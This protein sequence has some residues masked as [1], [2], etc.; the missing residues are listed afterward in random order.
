MKAHNMKSLKIKTGSYGLFV[1]QNH[2]HS[3][4]Y[5]THLH[6]GL[7]RSPNCPKTNQPVIYLEKVKITPIQTS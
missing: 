1:K 3:L 4:L 7:T 6:T 2:T 5:D